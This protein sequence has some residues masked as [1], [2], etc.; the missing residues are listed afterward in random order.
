MRFLDFVL[1]VIAIFWT[2]ARHHSV[3]TR[4]RRQSWWLFTRLMGNSGI[5]STLSLILMGH[6]V[7]VWHPSPLINILQF[8]HS[9]H[10]INTLSQCCDSLGGLFLLN[11][12]LYFISLCLLPNN[13]K[14]Q[15]MSLFYSCSQSEIEN[16]IRGLCWRAFAYLKASLSATLW[17]WMTFF[18][19]PPQNPIT[20]PSTCLTLCP[21]HRLSPN[22]F[23][24]LPPRGWVWLMG[25][26]TP[27]CCSV[28]NRKV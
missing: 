17:Y 10:L 5:S 27:S 7:T 23:P 4:V 16:S 8:W 20:H 22:P 18:F 1:T 13:K 3:C 28:P 26:G 12:Y 21:L 19:P 9:F 2:P 14:H 24:S 6:C 25:L 15:G 11:I